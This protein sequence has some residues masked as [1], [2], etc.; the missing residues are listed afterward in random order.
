M[1]V[2]EIFDS[3]KCIRFCS[4]EEM[5]D[6]IERYGEVYYWDSRPVSNTKFAFW[7]EGMRQNYGKVLVAYNGGNYISGFWG[8]EYYAEHAKNA[9]DYTA[10]HRD[11]NLASW[12]EL[13]VC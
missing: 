5:N 4:E 8:A 7:Y 9:V 1:T 13:M 11:I 10:I 2:Q 3:G 6:F 12:E